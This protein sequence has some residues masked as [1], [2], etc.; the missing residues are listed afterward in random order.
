[1]EPWPEAVHGQALLDELAEALRR[2]VV[3]PEWGPETLALWIVLTYA[4]DL[5]D[6]TAYLGVESPDK[7]CGKTTLLAILKESI[8]PSPPPI[9][10]HRRSIE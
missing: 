9:S 3:L 8:D 1:M 10:V 5:R 7:R 4:F 6:V 2:F